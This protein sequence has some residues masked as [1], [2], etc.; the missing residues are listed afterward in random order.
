MKPINER[1]LEESLPLAQGINPLISAKDMRDEIELWLMAGY[2]PVQQLRIDMIH[3]YRDRIGETGRWETVMAQ[4]VKRELPGKNL[5][6]ATA[7]DTLQGTEF[8]LCLPGHFADEFEVL[9]HGLVSAYRTPEPKFE[10]VVTEPHCKPK[11]FDTIDK[12]AK[13]IARVYLAAK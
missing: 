6:I 11:T 1:A 4:L 5:T 9:E 10:F 3:I 7:Q 12:A 2:R 13:E 8:N